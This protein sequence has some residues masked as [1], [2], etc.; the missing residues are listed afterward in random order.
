MK[1]I[2]LMILMITCILVSG[3]SVIN[4]VAPP[5]PDTP[6]PTDSVSQPT[7]TPLPTL[8]EPEF[9]DAAYCWE[10]HIDEGEYN[11]VRFFPSGLLIDVFVQP[12]TSCAEAWA[13][14]KE[15]LI[16]ESLMNFNHG[17]YH[18]SENQIRYTLSPPNSEEVSGEILGTYTINSM[19][20]NRVGSDERVYIL[21]TT[22]E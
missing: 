5:P 14:T 10:S 18:L 9:I 1:K 6:E 11:L 7:N 8:G 2:L 21:I 4:E 17:E 3:C 12:Y 13:N 19:L 15:Y 20:L 16:E 22:G